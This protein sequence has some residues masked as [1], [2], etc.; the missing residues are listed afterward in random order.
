M[1][2]EIDFEPIGIRAT[3]H[4]GE[5][6]LNVAQRAGVMLAAICGGTGSCGRCLIQVMSGKTS[7]ANKIEEN[8]LEGD[9]LRA[10]WRLS[11]QTEAAGDIRVHIPPE[12]LVTSQRIQLEGQSPPVELDPPVHVFDVELP[13]PTLDDLR[14]D[15]M[16]LRDRLCCPELSS[17][18]S[19]LRQ[20][21]ADLRANEY[22]PT[23]FVKRQ[24]L[25]GIRPARTVPLGL[26]TDIGTT[27]L[28]AYL[29]DLISGKTLAAIGAMN[30]QIAFGEDVMSRIGHANCHP[31]GQEQL[32]NVIIEALN[33]LAHDLCSQ[34][35]REVA[36]IAEAVL[37]G[38]TAMHHLLLGLPVRQLGVAPFVAVESAALDLP[39]GDV[40]LEIATGASVYLL[41]NIAG[42]VGG[43]HVAMLLAAGFPEADRIV[44]GIDIGTNTEISLAAKGRHY[45]CSTASGP[46]FEG[47]H[48]RC[49]MRA[50]PGAIEEVLIRDDQVLIRTIENSPPVGL[51]GSGM[52]DLVAQMRRAGI[53]TALGAMNISSGH[54]RLRSGKKGLEFIVVPILHDGGTEITFSRADVSQVQLAKG[55]MRSGINILLQR[56]GISELDIDEI[57]I[58]GAF[59]TI[60]MFKAPS[61]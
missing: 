39:A 13:P 51:C 55:A 45:T 61:T 34:A 24:S 40:G 35:G 12:S 29:V 28:A 52:L 37:A 33:R 17:S 60:S 44:L 32:R 18:L 5:T 20:M 50:A 26:A 11:C 4:S 6:I 7:P 42:F 59:E 41:P 16:R 31:E 8:A 1:S 36:D 38:N 15:A 57:I 58:A 46:A 14:S 10:G 30:P 47:A 53:L 54:P 22:R 25:V 2:F 19:V 56:A 21:P 48:I 43:D 27:K 9:Q 23:V 49:G 3:C